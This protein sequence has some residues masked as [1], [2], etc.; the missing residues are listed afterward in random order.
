MLQFLGVG[1]FNNDGKPDLVGSLQYDAGASVLLNIGATAAAT[2]TT[3]SPTAPQSY[4]ELQP[5]TFTAQIHHTGPGTPT[6]TVEFLDSGVL[7]GSASVD[8]N[9]Q[10]LFTTTDLAVGSHF[11]VAYYQGDNNFAPSN[12]LGVH[13]IINKAHTSTTLTSSQSPSRYGE[14]LTFTAAVTGQYGGT[15][16]GTVSFRDGPTTLGTSSLKGGAAKFS[17]AKLAV[18]HHC[19]RAAYSGDTNFAAS[20]SPTLIQVVHRATTTTMLVSSLN[21]PTGGLSVTFT[22]TVV[23]QYSGTPTGT[24]T[25]KNGTVTMGKVR[26]R[27]GRANFNKVFNSTGT[28]SITATYSGDA[29]FTPSAAELTQNFN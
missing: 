2:T 14:K 22:A 8:S 25:F 3:I 17:T 12:S 27:G 20:T 5:V 28:K 29:N 10:A 19:I 26:L 7:I 15:P 11:V 23:P 4:S 9:G 1:D 21:P 6:S 18:G 16:T 24:V 13:V